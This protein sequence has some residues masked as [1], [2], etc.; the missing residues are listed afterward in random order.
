[1]LIRALVYVK[2]YSE[3]GRALKELT[4]KDSTWS[5]SGLL[6][7]SIVHK[8]AQECHLEFDLIWN[9][10]RQ[11]TASTSGTAATGM[12]STSGMT[13]TDDDDADDEEITE[14]LH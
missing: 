12:S 8:I 1:M 11:V 9:A 10:G 2:D 5:A 6:D 3:A 13:T 4:V 7:R 14:E